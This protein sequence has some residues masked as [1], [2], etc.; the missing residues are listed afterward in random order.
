[1][2]VKKD[3]RIDPDDLR[4]D[5]NYV[6]GYLR[7]KGVTREKIE[8]IRQVLS[9]DA[10]VQASNL[11]HDR[12]YTAV[13]LAGYRAWDFE[14]EKGLEL[15]KHFEK[16]ME[17]VEDEDGKNWPARMKELKDG[18]GIVIITGEGNRVIV[19]SVLD[20]DEEVEEAE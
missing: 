20:A 11:K 14:G 10:V 9:A 13:A 8:W 6:M 5:L 4:R 19:E 15:L 12:I 18:A 7:T 3:E 16:I 1:M 2:R 17:D